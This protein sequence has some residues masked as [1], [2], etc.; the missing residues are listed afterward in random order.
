V[1]LGLFSVY[2]Q[3]EDTATLEDRQKYEID[4]R[5]ML[6]DG[7]AKTAGTITFEARLPVCREPD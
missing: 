4:R 1:N 6:P 2:L 5:Y 7:T 3:E